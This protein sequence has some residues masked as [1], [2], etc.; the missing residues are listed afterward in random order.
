MGSID[1]NL[2]ELVKE[3]DM[4]KVH[5]MLQRQVSSQLINAIH[6]LLVIFFSCEQ[7]VTSLISLV[8]NASLIQR[9]LKHLHQKE[10]SMHEQLHGEFEDFIHMVK[11]N[12]DKRLKAD[13]KDRTVKIVTGFANLTNSPSNANSKP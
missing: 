12:S 7:Q 10:E 8:D 6:P 4:D 13:D 3:F 5:P 2:S 1:D 9:R 11:E